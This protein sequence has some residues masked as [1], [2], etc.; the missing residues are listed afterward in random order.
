MKIFVTVKLK[1]K[2]NKIEKIDDNHF[3][4]FI[5]ELPVKGRANKTILK[6]LAKYLGIPISQ[7]I[8]K[9]GLK[10]KR[11]IIEIID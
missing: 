2:D 11:K 1:S 9:S 3:L 5:K 8:I 4:I 7:L 6:L 10:S